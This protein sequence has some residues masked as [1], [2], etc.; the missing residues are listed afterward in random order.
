MNRLAGDEAAIVADQ[1]QAGRGDLVDMSLAAQ[2]NA[3][4]A[5]DAALIP[6]GIVSP[7]IDTAGGDNV[8]PD[9]IGG[10]LGGQ[11]PRHAYQAHLC[12]RDMSAP[13]AAGKGAIAGEEKNPPVM[14]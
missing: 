9:V 10:E 13:L 6:F 12:R 14:V 1:E 4:G 8:D 11:R 5:R 7:G 3:G 2:R